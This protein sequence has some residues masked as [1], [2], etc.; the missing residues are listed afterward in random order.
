MKKLICLSLPLAIAVLV[1]WPDVSRAQSPEVL[2][3]LAAPQTASALQKFPLTICLRTDLSWLAIAD[4]THLAALKTRDLAFEVLDDA[5][6]SQPYYLVSR[7]AHVTNKILPKVGKLLWQEDATTLLKISDEEAGALARQ[8]WQLARVFNRALPQTREQA[9]FHS[10]AQTGKATTALIQ[11]LNAEISD[12]SVTLYLERLEAFRTRFSFSDS[13]VPAR[14]WLFQQF[15]EHGYAEVRFDPVP[16]FGSLQQN[17][18]ATKPGTFN[19]DRVIVLG[20]HYDSILFDADPQLFAPGVDDDGT[21]TAGTL[22]L[23]RVLAETDLETTLFFVPFA[24]E[25]Q[26]LWGSSQFAATAFNTGM[27][28][29]LMLNMD[30]IGNVAD[31][32]LNLNVLTDNNSRGYAQLFARLTTQHTNLLP[33][34]GGSSANSD[35]FPFQQFGFP[36]LFIHEGDFSP[37]WHT[38]AD[39]LSNINVPYATSV[40]KA[41]LAMI[42]TVANS[43]D[44]PK[45]FTASEPGDGVSQ[46]LQW[47]AN[48]EPDLAGYRLHLGKSRGVYDDVYTLTV[49]SDTL[50]GLVEGQTYFAALS[51]FDTQGNE[52]LLSPEI[53]FTPQNAPQAPAGFDATS[54]KSNVLLTWLATNHEADFAGYTLTRMAP[55]NMEQSFLLDADATSFSDASAQ[56]HVLYRYYLQARDRDGNLSAPTKERRGRLATHDHGILIVDGTKDGASRPLQPSDGEVDLFYERILQSFN[57]A[58]Q[59]DLADSVVQGQQVSDAD[60]GIYSTLVW[61]SEVN[62]PTRRLAS[63][64]LALRKYLQNGGRLLLVGWGLAESLV[65]RNF[66]ENNFAPGQFGYDYLQLATSRTAAGSDRDFKGAD[67]LLPNYPSVTIDPVK[68]P[69]FG[70]NL[71]AMEIFSALAPGAETQA[72][73]A[74][75][76]SV[77]PPSFYH[78]KSVALKYLGQDFKCIVLDFPL[79]FLNEPEAQQLL[80]QA[81]LDLGESATAVATPPASLPE[82]FALEQS[83]PNPVRIVDFAN[84]VQ[85]ERAHARIRYHL[86]RAAHVTIRV[87]NL[88]GQTVRTLVYGMMPAGTQ[89]V[90]WN[91]KNDAGKIAVAGVYFYEM[92]AED[93]RQVKKLVMAP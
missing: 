87:Y 92:R 3:R 71:L 17:V 47:Q 38:S 58:G 81:L 39:V 31:Q 49:T 64:T 36:A 26:G 10:N 72:L 29:G 27:N 34:L 35:H 90:F 50:R 40:M 73:Y 12:S 13:I 70:G 52:S 69:V 15:Q 93:F 83:Y 77:Q 14:E 53:K 5:P 59:W 57:N 60:L 28:I 19:T 2:L 16:V 23:A 63:D 85:P 46:I 75:R 30:M 67:P 33:A 48:R 8:G 24:A 88:L 56:P 43:P 65:G 51:A 76:S 74:Y 44:V 22:E 78:G 62:A 6:F 32:I 25:E 18:V 41:V 66:V 91:G 79:Y 45:G 21:G 86:P 37:N 11:Q 1:V 20:G 4:R 89:L 80:R 7:T 82:R 54:R 61:H 55:E 9:V 42:V 84:N 68:V